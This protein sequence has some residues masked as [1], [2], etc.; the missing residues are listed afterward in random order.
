MIEPGE[1]YC[2]CYGHLMREIITEDGD[3]RHESIT[4]EEFMD[5]NSYF[6]VND[7]EFIKRQYGSDGTIYEKQATIDEYLEYY[8]QQLSF[9]EFALF[10]KVNCIRLT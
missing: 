4:E 10:D 3:I 7:G 9:D 8:Q 6:L 1:T 2:R 5:E